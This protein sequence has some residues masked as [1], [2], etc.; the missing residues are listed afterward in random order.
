MPH[1]TRAELDAALPHILAA[2]KNDAAIAMLCLRPGF[3]LRRFV[4][5]V[6]VT[7]AGGI[8]GERWTSAPWLRHADGSPHAG[9][10]ISI[11]SLIHI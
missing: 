3:N 4:D 7:R 6:T 2:P 11:L 5:A 10:Q 8:A 9:I 1:A